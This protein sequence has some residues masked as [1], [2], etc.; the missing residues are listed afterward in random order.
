VV[1]QTTGAFSMRLAGHALQAGEL[2]SS[3]R[4]EVKAWH[5]TTVLA[6]KISG[7]GE[8]RVGD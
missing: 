8:V 4:V 5:S 6:G 2:G 3:I 1:T 7:K